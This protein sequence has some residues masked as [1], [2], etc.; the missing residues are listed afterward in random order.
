MDA[1]WGTSIVCQDTSAPTTQAGVFSSYGN[2]GALHTPKT[3]PKEKLYLHGHKMQTKNF[4]CLEPDHKSLQF[5]SMQRKV[6]CFDIEHAI[7]TEAAHVFHVHVPSDRG[8]IAF[9]KRHLFGNQVVN[10]HFGIFIYHS[11]FVFRGR[12]VQAPDG[13]AMLDLGK[14][15]Q[16]CANKYREKGEKKNSAKIAT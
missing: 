6:P 14:H 5:L 4:R 1:D 8:G 15:P 7:A 11:Q 16:N 13:G 12:Q 3:V 10:E 9:F 2:L